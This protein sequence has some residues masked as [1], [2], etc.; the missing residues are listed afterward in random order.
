MGGRYVLGIGLGVVLGGRYVLGS[1][2][3]TC[4]T[5]YSYP[6]LGGKYFGLIE[7]RENQFLSTILT[8]KSQSKLIKNELKF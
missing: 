1:S 8:R 7:Y 5:G 2:S 6:C 3:R 4:G